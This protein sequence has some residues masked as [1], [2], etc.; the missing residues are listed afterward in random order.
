MAK[1]KVSKN[2]SKSKLPAVAEKRLRPYIDKGISSGIF[3]NEDPVVDLF[4]RTSKQPDLTQTIKD[5]GGMKSEIAQAF[6]TD[7]VLIDLSSIL[8]QKRYTAHMEIWEKSDR[9][10]NKAD[11]GTRA[12]CFIMGQ[13]TI[14]DGGS[15][16]EPAIFRMSLWENDVALADD[17][18][19]GQ[20]YV[21]SVACRNLDLDILDL[22]PLGGM[23]H[24]KSE[25][26]FKHSSR[27]DILRD[28][29]EISDIADLADDVSR[30]PDDY[31]LIEATVS[32]SGVKTSRNG[33]QFGTMLL[34]D[35]STMTMDAIES[36]ENLLLNAI[37]S[38][39]LVSE[40]GK[41][42]KILGL[43]H[44]KNSD[45]WGMS[46]NLETAFG[47]VTVSPPTPEVETGGDDDDDD[48]ADYFKS[49]DSVPMVGDDDEEEEESDDQ[50]EESEDEEEEESEDEEEEESD[51]EEEESDE[52]EEESKTDADS[53]EEDD[54]DDWD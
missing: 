15:T 44:T 13:T 25:K 39:D 46:A 7:A 54:W 29:Y 49:D 11:G 38:L 35:D 21:A 5:L 34:K 28:M 12:A 27:E 45:Q 40:F 17:L 20:Q 16:M 1:K 10:F 52:E 19:R 32:Y 18:E 36:G 9:T 42:S 53:D 23:T 8:R 33:N 2:A 51:E 22:K 50:E 4:R 14:E 3:T 26:K 47:I 31:R 24:F 6:V 48:A 43:V 41:Y 30:R 37:C